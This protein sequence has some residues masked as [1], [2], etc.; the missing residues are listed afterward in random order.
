VLHLKIV[1][2]ATTSY[3]KIEAKLRNLNA[4][5]LLHSESARSLIS[6]VHIQQFRLADRKLQMFTTDFTYVTTFEY[7]LETGG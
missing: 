1:D 3:A 6:F 5:V 4:S 2:F 7:S